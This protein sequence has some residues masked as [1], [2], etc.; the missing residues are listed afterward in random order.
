MRTLHIRKSQSSS[1]T[2]LM[3]HPR[4][5][6]P[7][8]P[9][10]ALSHIL[11]SSLFPRP[12]PYVWDG[13]ALSAALHLGSLADWEVK[14]SFTFHQV[15]GPNPTPHFIPTPAPP[16]SI[17]L[18]ALALG[19]KV[20]VPLCEMFSPL[21]PFSVVVNL[22]DQIQRSIQLWTLPGTQE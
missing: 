6:C 11:S 2:S 20:C 13:F 1:S 19:W 14:P 8:G 22:P 5:Q 7:V 17:F 4:G 9:A 18:P 21:H 12:L 10:S 15:P 3:C 16:S